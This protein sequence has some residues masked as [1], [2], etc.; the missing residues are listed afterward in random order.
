MSGTKLFCLRQNVFSTAKKLI[1]A[2]YQ[3]KKI[4]LPDETV[5]FCTKESVF[6]DL[7]MAEM[8]FLDMD[9]IF[10]LRQ[11]IFV[12][13]KFDFVLADGMGMNN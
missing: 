6:R 13:D 5:N 1:S 7:C 11:N 12:P 10:C 8:N 4:A 2:T 3:S 9:K